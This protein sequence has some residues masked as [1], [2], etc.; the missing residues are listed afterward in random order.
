MKDG[1][2]VVKGGATVTTRSSTVGAQLGI[3]YQF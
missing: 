2:T 3:G 1:H